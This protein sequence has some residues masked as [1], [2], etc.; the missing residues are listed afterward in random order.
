[1]HMRLRAKRSILLLLPMAAMLHSAPGMSTTVQAAEASSASV[2]F[3][4]AIADAKKAMMADPA[5][6]LKPVLQAEKLA[7]GLGSI[8]AVQTGQATAEWLHG[9][10]LSRMNQPDKAMP[11]IQSALSLSTK[12]APESKLSADVTLARGT[13][14]E[15]LGDVRSSLNDFQ[16]AYTIYLKIADARGQAK[17]LLSIGG[18]YSDGGD[19]ARSLH[20]Y[21][22]VPEAYHG[23]PSMDLAAHNNLGET[24]KKVG[25]YKDAEKEYGL[26]LAAARQLDSQMLEVRILSNMASAQL[27]RGAMDEADQTAL[28]ALALSS[29]GEAAGWR[30]F[31]W[32][33]RAQIA[34][35]RGDLKAADT[36]LQ[37]TFQGVDL[38]KSPVAFLD[39]HNTASE[40]YQRLGNYPLAYAHLKAFK[41][42]DDDTQKITATSSAALLA[43]RFDFANQN[44][45]I[46]KL[47]AQKLKQDA[48]FIQT[49]AH[50]RNMV[51]SGLLA[52]G[53]VLISILLVAF[54]SISRSRNRVR[55]ANA[56]LQEANASLEK[57]LK[58]KDEFLATTSHEIRTPL[59]GILGMTQVLLADNRLQ[60]DMRERVRV[61]HGAGETMRALV[62]DIL[63]LAKI[64][65]GNLTIERSE[66]DLKLLL[67]EA[68]KFWGGQA[69][70][71]GLT[72]D[73]ELGQAPYSIEEDE[74]RL[75][76]IIF[77]LMSNAIK[78]T[79]NGSIKLRADKVAG[80]ED[81]RLV[82]SVR[83]TGIGIAG[84]KLALIFESFR[85]V[86]SG[87]TRRYGGTG[88][89]L[90]ICRQLAK[91][92]GGDVTVE[93]A[94]G[95]GSTFTLNL[96]LRVVE[97]RDTAFVADGT[98]APASSLI[99]SNLL[100]LEGN[101]LTQR[102]FTQV[103]TPHIR[104]LHPVAEA[105]QARALIAS[106]ERIDHILVEATSAKLGTD[107]LIT[108][109]RR[110]AENAREIGARFSILF[111]P[112]E[113]LTLQD[114]VL[115]GADQIITKPIGA[116]ALI[117]ALQALYI[118][119]AQMAAVGIPDARMSAA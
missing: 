98:A 46:D 94:E 50:T 51:L 55:A 96:P 117:Q 11:Y 49:K 41:R 3:D 114:M 81:Q 78:F 95:T 69:E 2:G 7:N 105:E 9:E 84:D 19:D 91:A 71:K 92:M 101:A 104:R 16:R 23:D 119:P 80:P 83:D 61:V 29:A 116:P 54:V 68:V 113:V 15:A 21:E 52:G 67:S 33:V 20:Y 107:D 85:Q 109:L 102:I 40:V 26:A 82:I 103:L 100:M 18:I 39:F 24:L 88:L 110:F 27:L 89:G 14:E 22:M 44:V 47:R 59:N 42:L 6:A 34:L 32:G 86:D 73:V 28:R 37:K 79:E 111:T 87:T 12:I 8:Q 64:E 30:P 93:S 31:I 74:G 115:V 48:L 112:S 38:T 53:A 58:V 77:N 56:G 63:D 13:A 118:R 62:D 72:I 5:S 1:M 60:E 17:A 4:A 10:A 76:Q 66:V 97:H 90:A 43:A 65:T 25:R 45:R 99:E 106:G 36:Y 75:R 57:A 70:A 35:Q 108:S